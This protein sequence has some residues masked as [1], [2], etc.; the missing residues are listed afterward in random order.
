MNAP[1]LE[2]IYPNA[3]HGL[4][5]LF[6]GFLLLLG[7]IATVI[8]GGALCADDKTAVGVPL[9]IL[10][11]LGIPGTVLVWRGLVLVNPNQ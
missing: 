5:C 6:L 8:M 11:L 2:R 7:S 9:L 10:G 4:L 1:S 3:G